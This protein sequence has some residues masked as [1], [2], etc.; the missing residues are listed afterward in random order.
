MSEERSKISEKRLVI[1]TVAISLYALLLTSLEAE[2]RNLLQESR[3]SGLRNLSLGLSLGICPVRRLTY[4]ASFA[5]SQGL[6][7]FPHLNVHPTARM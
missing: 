7:A 6:L 4:C 5:P 1:S 3:S 2:F